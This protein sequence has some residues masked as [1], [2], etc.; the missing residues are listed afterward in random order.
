MRDQDQLTLMSGGKG[1]PFSITAIVRDREESE[2]SAWSVDGDGKALIADTV[3]NGIAPKLSCCAG[4]PVKP[5]PVDG[6]VALKTSD[7]D[8]IYP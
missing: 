2:L 7:D 8:R 5:L 4:R 3:F 6:V 1:D